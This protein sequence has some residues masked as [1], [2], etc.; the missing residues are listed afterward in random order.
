MVGLPLGQAS[1]LERIMYG[2]QGRRR[3]GVLLGVAGALLLSLPT[4]GL[5]KVLAHIDLSAQRMSVVVDGEHFAYWAVSTA[6][7]GYHTPV[8]AF[9]PKVLRRRHYSSQFR[10]AM[11]YSVF[12]YRGYAIHGTEHVKQ[13]GRPASHGCIRLH[14][15]HAAQFF[16][17]VRGYGLHNTRIRISY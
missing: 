3:F 9:R 7:R 12:F 11:P 13:L 6:K 4:T 5:A 1:L 14:P 2:R 10:S 16:S 17:L 15:R 8:G